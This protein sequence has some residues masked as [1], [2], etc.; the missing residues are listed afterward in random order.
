MSIKKELSKVDRISKEKRRL[1]KTFKDIEENKRKVVEGLLD[2]SAFMRV[3]L[4]DIKNICKSGTTDELQQGEYT[5]IREHP[6]VKVYNTMVQRYTTMIKQLSNLL[7][8]DEVMKCNE[9]GFD[10]FINR[11]NR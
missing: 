4:I 8:P 7:P 2:D 6:N 10:D 11:R 9:D 3:T 1:K 5:I